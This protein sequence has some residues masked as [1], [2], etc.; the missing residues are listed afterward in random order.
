ML[1]GIPKEIKPNERRVGLV[2]E[3]V[4][5]VIAQGHQVLVE[6]NAGSGIG[7]NDEAYLAHGA[8]IATDAAK[9]FAK[10][11]MIVK[12]KE[13][14]AVECAMLRPEQILFTYLHLAPDP[15]QTQGLLDSGC[16]AVAY[17]TITQAR[18]GLPLL[19]PMSEVA[20][21]MAVQVGAAALEDIHGG[22]GIL[23]GGVPGV[24]PGKV[25]ILGG[26]VAGTNAM[27]MAVGLGAEVAVLDRDPDKLKHIDE[28]YKGRV[29]TVYSTRAAVER[30][31]LSADLVVGTV[32]IPGAAA[33]KL[34]TRELVNGMK[35]GSVIVDVAVDQGGCAETTHATTHN[36]PTYVVDGVVHYCVA[37]MPGGVARTSALALNN[38]TLPYVLRLAGGGL[39]ALLAD[40]H[41]LN[42]L[43][44]YSGSVTNQ[45]VARDL[46]LTYVDPASLISKRA[47]E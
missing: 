24:E 39:Q 20:G 10:A 34:I 8:E 30:H 38:A 22:R 46:G 37:N 47:V 35:D 4:A 25:T 11:D 36:D 12:V 13:P 6:T 44:I 42:G 33:P 31:V 21:R 28:I 27:V 18:G 16:I 32:L 5:E 40:H 29:Q 43:N 9:V 26:G 1:I 41:F 19:A 15:A 7:M 3:S 17:E 14:Q 23:L 45:A 2:P